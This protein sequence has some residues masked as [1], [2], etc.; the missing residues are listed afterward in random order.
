MFNQCPLQS[1]QQI[2]RVS[3]K[4]AVEILF[5]IGTLGTYTCLQMR[6]T[7]LVQE[8][9]HQSRVPVCDALC[10]AVCVVV[11]VAV[12]DTVCATAREA[13]THNAKT[14]LFYLC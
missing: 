10:V 9:K 11:C 6:R 8:C 4:S 12:C 13:V 1:L 7:A 2:I 14:H 5:S 3:E